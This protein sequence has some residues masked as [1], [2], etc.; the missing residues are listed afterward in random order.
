MDM[1]GPIPTIRRPWDDGTDS[2]ENAKRR[3]RVAFEFFKR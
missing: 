2:L 1:F 3:I